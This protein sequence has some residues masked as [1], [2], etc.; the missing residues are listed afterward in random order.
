M[1]D[2]RV[3]GQLLISAI[4]A[5]LAI[6]IAIPAWRRVPTEYA[7][8]LVFAGALLGMSLMRAELALRRRR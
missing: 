5:A 3:A 1:P 7:I 2:R 6:V 4:M 8:P